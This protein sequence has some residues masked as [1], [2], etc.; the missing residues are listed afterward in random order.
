[1]VGRRS[2]NAFGNGR[3]N[4]HSKTNGDRKPAAF[5]FKDCVNRAVEDDHR[6]RI[7]D[8]LIDAVKGDELESFRKSDDEVQFPGGPRK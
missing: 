1:M 3:A 6:N 2:V 7:K 5:R 8:T 4:S